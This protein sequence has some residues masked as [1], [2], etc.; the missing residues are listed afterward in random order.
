MIIYRVTKQT[1]WASCACNSEEKCMK[2][3]MELYEDEDFCFLCKRL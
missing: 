3:E 2:D 1:K